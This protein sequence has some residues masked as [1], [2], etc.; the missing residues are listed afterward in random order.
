MSNGIYSSVERVGNIAWTNSGSEEETNCRS[1]KIEVTRS[2]CPVWFVCMSIGRV[3]CF[4][5]IP[6]VQVLLSRH[7]PEAH[8]GGH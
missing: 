2:S 1:V 6:A 8:D 7:A 5:R 4:S 3:G